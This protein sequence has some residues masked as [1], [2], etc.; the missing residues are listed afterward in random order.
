I[1]PRSLGVN[2]LL[3]ISALAER[4][5]ALLATDRG[6]VIDN[7][8]PTPDP[9]PAPPS[10][11]GIE[12]TE[13][14]AGW[15][16]TGATIPADPKAAAEAGRAAGSPL[17]FV[18]TIVARDLDRFL[19]DPEHT[20]RMV[21]TVTAPALSPEPLPAT[22]GVFNLFMDD[23][24]VVDLV[25]MRY[26]MTLTAGDGHRYLFTGRKDIRHDR[27]LDLWPDTTTL[28]T[29][30]YDGDDESGTVVARGILRIAP[31]DF[32]QQMRSTRATGAT[33]VGERLAAEARFG[34]AFAGELYRVYGGVATGPRLDEPDAPPRKKRD[35]RAP[36]PSI[37]PFV[38]PDGLELRLTRYQGGVKGPVLVTHGLGVSS[39]IF[40]IDTIQTNLVEALCAHGYDVWLLDYRA[41]IALPTAAAKF[42]ADDVARI[43]YPA[44]VAEVLRL[45]GR[46]SVQAL[47][48]CF[49]AT[50]FTM[51]MLHGLEHVRAAVLSQV[52]THVLVPTV[53][54]LKAGLHVPGALDVL[55]LDTL[56]A[57]ATKGERWSERLFD[58]ALAAYPMQA[59]EHCASATCHRISFLYA[60]LYEHDQLN[61][62]THDALGEMFGVANIQAFEHLA[63]MVRKGTVVSFEDDFDY[64]DHYDRLAIPLTIVHGAEN[65]CFNPESTERTVAALSKVNDPGL[66]TRHLVPGYGHIDCIF[67]KNAARDVYPLMIQG[68]EPSALP[69]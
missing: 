35:L 15:A 59:E 67:G 5:A 36:A 21:G 4:T 64:L 63:K 52:S 9:G 13:R 10:V 65:V 18:V 69:S 24:D 27:P 11:V 61:T 20:A 40:T 51:A 62:S 19:A 6:W 22:G 41:S 39:L 66:Y 50:T 42:D 60:L 37:H 25:H 32:M 55:G 3:T 12:F 17:S 44:A 57:R 7:D 54:K 1:V 29:T 58:R 34:K 56:D 68:L 46:S 48:H 30:V 2:P 31:T 49:G 14:M 38:T 28:Y 23:P 16:A 33:G 53:G 43:D 47:A 8:S 45:T 26:R